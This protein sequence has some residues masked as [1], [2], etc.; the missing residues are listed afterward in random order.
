MAR[1]SLLIISSSVAHS[2]GISI[3]EKDLHIFT[4]TYIPVNT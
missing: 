1:L 4:T 2:R 3:F